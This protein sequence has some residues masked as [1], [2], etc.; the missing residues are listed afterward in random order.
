MTSAS[1]TSPQPRAGLLASGDEVRVHFTIAGLGGSAASVKAIS[2]AVDRFP[3]PS[4]AVIS[5]A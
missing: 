1:D 2:A 3:R 5:S 4:T